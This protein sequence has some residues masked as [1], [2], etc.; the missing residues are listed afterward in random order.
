MYP[1]LTTAEYVYHMCGG[2]AMRERGGMKEMY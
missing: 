2:K 1:Y